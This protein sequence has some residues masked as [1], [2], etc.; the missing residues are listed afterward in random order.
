MAIKKAFLLSAFLYAG[1]VVVAQVGTLNTNNNNPSPTA[2]SL[3]KFVEQPVSYYSGIP[4]ISIPI[5]NMPIKGSNI[6]ITLSYRAAG[7]KVNDVAGLTGLGW[8]LN[9]GGTITR[10]VRGFPDD[11]YTFPNWKNDYAVVTHG[12]AVSAYHNGLNTLFPTVEDQKNFYFK[13]PIVSSEDPQITVLPP[14]DTECDIYYY[15]ILGY[16]GRFTLNHNGKAVMMPASDLK[17]ER[18]GQYFKITDATGLMFYFEDM[19]LAQKNQENESISS[20]YVSRIQSPL[21]N[22]TVFF[23][24]KDASTGYDAYNGEVFTS[25]AFSEN[26]I[27]MRVLN[28]SFDHEAAGTPSDNYPHCSPLSYSFSSG[29][30]RYQNNLIIDEVRYK[31]GKV[32]FYSTNNRTDAYLWKIDS[33]KVINDNDLISRVAFNYGYFNSSNSYY[34]DKRLRLDSITT[35]DQPYTFSY[36]ES[37]NGKTLPVMTTAGK[38]L[39]GFYN[40]EDD[41]QHRPR[42]KTFS[43]MDN[44]QTYNY[45]STAE[46]WLLWNSVSGPNEF[47]YFG[48]ASGT[49][50]NPDYRYGQIGTLKSIHYPTGGKVEYE[51]EGNDFGNYSFNFPA[52]FSEPIERDPGTQIIRDTMQDV[53]VYAAFPHPIEDY[54]YYEDTKTS[55]V[56]IHSDQTVDLNVQYG[57]YSETTYQRYLDALYVWGVF[58]SCNITLSRYNTLTGN[59]DLVT[60]Y[61]LTPFDIIGIPNSESEFEMLKPSLFIQTAASVFLTEGRYKLVCQY[62][63]MDVSAYA[64]LKAKFYYKKSDSL[65]YAGGL[66]IKKVKFS[67]G[68]NLDVPIVKEYLYGENGVSYGVIESP[69]CNISPSAY[70]GE[71]S[72]YTEQ[73]DFLNIN[74]SSVIPLGNAQG[75]TIG[76]SRVIE[77]TEGAGSSIYNFTTGLTIEPGEAYADQYRQK[78][79]NGIQTRTHITEDNSWKRGLLNHLEIKNE[80][81]S[82]V[83][84]TFYKYQFRKNTKDTS[85]SLIAEFQPENLTVGLYPYGYWFQLHQPKK[86][87][88]VL[89]SVITYGSVSAIAEVKRY[90]YDLNKHVYPI[91][92]TIINSYGKKIITNYKYPLDYAVGINPVSA[93]SKGIKRLQES[94]TVSSAIEVF[95]QV[96]DAGVLKTTGAVLTSF[97]EDKPLPDKEYHLQI[98]GPITDFSPSVFSSSAE[99]YDLRYKQRML[100]EGYDSKGNLV[101]KRKADDVVGSF[102]WGNSIIDNANSD[103]GYLTA[104]IINAVAEEVAYTSFEGGDPGNW[105]IPSAARDVTKAIAGRSSYNLSS[106]ALTCPPLNVGKSY[107][108]S[109]WSYGAHANI[110]GLTAVQGRTVNGWTYYEHAIPAGTTSVVVSGNVTIDELRL[111]PVGAQMSTYTY[112]ALVGMT[113]Q[114]DT[115]NRITYYEYDYFKRLKLVKDQDGNIIRRICYNYAGQ[116]IDCSK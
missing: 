114:T 107:I 40:G 105:V 109:Y 91:S 73:C 72:H 33:I 7:I 57:M 80:A 97:R 70:V 63:G 12:Y 13:T 39:W 111:H 67:T 22:D 82:L 96:Q 98:D 101:Q 76:Y 78:N 17:I 44:H 65:Y 50:R 20:W 54:G 55:E 21:S 49:V 37:Y 23:K 29:L 4:D 92:E 1:I 27:K 74:E 71:T 28:L 83:R 84:E 42:Y 46:Q 34:L 110:S 48:G 15:N 11:Y 93:F 25:S 94:N 64:N 100:F 24:Y 6:P 85:I 75:G 106:G 116:P 3:G 8:T 81:G 115:N 90:E 9:C 52:T 61:S 53:S 32:K 113:S 35:S 30:D 43:L 16:S 47:Y 104:Q 62:A 41:N 56:I 19:E 99:I 69:Y 51:Y 36:I 18:I 5:Y 14:I 102:I 77:K 59:Y 2:S 60:S 66:R 87:C 10:V 86:A 79:F 58:T 31:K 88:K 68:N 45:T 95:Q 26:L 89:D 112:D 38:D 108:V 103:Y